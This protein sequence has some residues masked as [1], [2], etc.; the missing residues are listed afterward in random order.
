MLRRTLFA[1]A[2]AT[3]LAPPSAKADKV[4]RIAFF[5]VAAGPNYLADAFKQGL[6]DLGYVEGRNLFI[7]YRWMAGRED[8]YRDVARELSDARVDL[9]VTAGHPPALAA[10]SATSQ[11]PIVGLAVV[12]PVGSGLVASLSHP[13]Q[14]FT[15]FSLEVTPETNAKMIQLFVGGRL[16]SDSSRGPLELGEPWQPRLPRCGASGGQQLRIALQAF[17]VRRAEDVDDMFRALNGQVEGLVVFPE[18]LLWTHRRQIVDTARAALLP[19]I[20]GTAMPLNW[21]A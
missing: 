18:G 14:N 12:D 16:C 11:I 19:T 17:D 3:I 7:D 21:V 2:F 6:R 20:L 9:I 15:G 5:S 13:G 4:W 1:G 10:K 8:Q